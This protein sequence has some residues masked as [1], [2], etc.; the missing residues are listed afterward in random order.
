[1]ATIK[2]V[3]REFC[4]RSNLPAP[5]AF[6]GVASPTEQQYLSL[7]AQVGDDLR[8]RPYNWSCLKRPYYFNTQTGV[9]KYQLPGDFYRLLDTAQW[10]VTNQWPMRG[11]ITDF[12]MAYR[13]FAVV[14]LQNRKGYRL[15]GPTNYLYNVAPYNQRSA[16]TFELDQEGQNNTDE[17]FLGYIS[18]NWV[19]PKDWVT[20]TVYAAGS[21]VAGS[22]NMYF[23]T[24]GG[25]SGATRPSV[26]T[27]SVSDGVV[28][29]EVYREPYLVSEVNT[30]LSDDDLV[31]FDKD[32]MIEGLKYAYLNAKKLPDEV[33]RANWEQTIK[34]SFTR[35]EAPSRGSMAQESYSDAEWPMTPI[36]SWNV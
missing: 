15:V 30:K 31:L 23:T 32:L 34:N 4:F 36:G 20:N 19:W 16:G 10:D 11:P 17:L 28:T 2:E 18:A 24:A 22:G 9:S 33:E 8:N 3:I 14:S 12:E 35:N 5:T 29:W 7:L 21:I 26:E 6:V 13:N 27:G 1:M 25:T